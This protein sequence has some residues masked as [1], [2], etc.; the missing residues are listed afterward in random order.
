[1]AVLQ[2]AYPFVSLA[3]LIMTSLLIVFR[4]PLGRKIAGL[5]RL[6]YTLLAIV[7]SVLATGMII[8]TVGFSTTDRE[9]NSY[10]LDNLQAFGLAFSSII[11]PAAVCVYSMR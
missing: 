10:M 3:C 8:K 2:S 4:I 11:P 1:M 6:D 7:S 5:F 9:T